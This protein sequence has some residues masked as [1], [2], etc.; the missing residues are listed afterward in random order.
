MAR[1]R[2]VSLALL[3]ALLAG[4]P[5]LGDA[6]A[7][8]VVAHPEAPEPPA[9]TDAAAVPD[10]PPLRVHPPAPPAGDPGLASPADPPEP[11]T[12]G[13]PVPRHVRFCVWRE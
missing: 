6:T 2:S 4:V 13:D 3:G 8:V 1:L 11:G 10:R 5:A 12:G 9:G 7:A